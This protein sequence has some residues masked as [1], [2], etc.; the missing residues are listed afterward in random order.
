MILVILQQRDSVKVFSGKRILQWLMSF[1]HA[2]DALPV[3]S[4]NRSIM[5]GRTICSNIFDLEPLEGIKQAAD[6]RTIHVE[7]VL[8]GDNH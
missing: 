5:S 3:N 1:P 4:T 2:K 7:H 6:D 8:D